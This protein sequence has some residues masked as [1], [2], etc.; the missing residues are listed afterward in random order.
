MAIKIKLQMK[1]LK[2]EVLEL[3]NLEEVGD[4]MQK[5]LCLKIRVKFLK[6]QEKVLEVIH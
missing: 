2:R 5:V 1:K 4:K 6:N 3:E